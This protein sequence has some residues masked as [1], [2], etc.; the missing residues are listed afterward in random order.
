MRYLDTS[1][2]VAAHGEKAIAA[3]DATYH[4]ITR[5]ATW[6]C[7]LRAR[8]GCVGGRNEGLRREAAVAGSCGAV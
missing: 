5:N 1:L 8:R 7:I 6:N 2:I 4:C 3:S